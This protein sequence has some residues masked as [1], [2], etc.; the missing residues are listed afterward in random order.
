MENKSFTLIELLVVIAVIGMLSSIVLVSLGGVRAKSR[1]AK[2]ISDL[3]QIQLAVEL[4]YDTYG[5]YPQPAGGWGVWSG[6]CPGYGNYDT[7]ILGLEPWLSPLPKDPKFDEG[8]QCYLY[9]S[10]GTDYI[11]ITHFTMETIC[12]GADGD[13]TPD[14]GDECNPPHIQA[15]DRVCCEQPTIAVYSPG[16]KNW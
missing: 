5:Q 1:D 2:R 11:I 3:K 15:M 13:S 8:G 10:N 6:H 4:Y 16:A 14:P 9:N 7:Y 12:D